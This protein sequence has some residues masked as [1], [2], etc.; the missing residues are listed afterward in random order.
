MCPQHGISAALRVHFIG[1]I[2]D[3]LDEYLI[4]ANNFNTE[5]LENLKNTF[6]EVIQFA[7][8]LFAEKAFYLWRRR[9]TKDGEKWGWFERSTT[10]V[11]DPLMYVLTGML[12]QKELYIAKADQIRTDIA[13]MYEENYTIFEGRNSN[14]RDI[15][16]RIFAYQNFFNKY[17]EA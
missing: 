7:Y 17:V 6:T 13:E 2:L 3:F 11:Y 4:N 12:N 9:K 14:R 8:D 15:E 16:K 10:T 1:Y 5:L